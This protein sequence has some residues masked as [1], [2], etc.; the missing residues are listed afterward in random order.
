MNYM[1]H[2]VI[3][4]ACPICSQG[5][6]LIAAEKDGQT[7]FVMCEDCESEWG[8]PYD[9]ADAALAT[10]DHHSFARYMEADELTDHPWYSA[11]L[12]K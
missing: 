2:A 5:R 10:R 9:S 6:V 3:S 8:S 12:N 11:I 4:E 1:H 7:L